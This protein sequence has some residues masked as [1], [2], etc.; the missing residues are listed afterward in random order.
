SSAAQG[1]ARSGSASAFR[2]VAF[3]S[4]LWGFDRQAAFTDRQ[5]KLLD[6]A[7]EAAGTKRTAPRLDL[8]RFYLANDMYAQA[9]GGLDL[10]LSDERPTADDTTGVVMRAVADIMLGRAEDGL[11]ALANPIVH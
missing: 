5:K 10:T 2:P 4:Q 7:A 3:D 8:A 1:A 11:M 6:A 9:K